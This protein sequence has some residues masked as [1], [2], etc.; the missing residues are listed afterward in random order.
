MFFSRETATRILHTVASSH[1]QTTLRSISYSA[2]TIHEKLMPQVAAAGIVLV[3]TTLV[4]CTHIQS[5]VS[6]Y[7]QLSCK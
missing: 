6:K 3:G 5:S 1:N 2:C 4:G 7:L